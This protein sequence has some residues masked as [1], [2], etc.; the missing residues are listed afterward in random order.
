MRIRRGTGNLPP[1]TRICQDFLSP[2]EMG[3]VDTPVLVPLFRKSLRCIGASLEPVSEKR[4]PP[5]PSPSRKGRGYPNPPPLRGREGWGPAPSSRP[6]STANAKEMAAK[7]PPSFPRKREPS[8]AG[9]GI[10]DV[11]RFAGFRM[12]RVSRDCF[13]RNDE[14]CVPQAGQ[15]FWQLPIISPGCHCWLGQQFV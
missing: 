11:P 7:P 12:S 1:E 6:T 5:P 10:P 4:L 8:P 14:I 2:S 9:R 13:R 3:G 15:K